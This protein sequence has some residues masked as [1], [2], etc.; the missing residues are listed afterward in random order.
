MLFGCSDDNTEIEINK[1]I[2]PVVADV[3]VVVSFAY[4]TGHPFRNRS[5]RI[6]RQKRVH[7]AAIQFH[8][9]KTKQ[10]PV[11]KFKQFFQVLG[12]TINAI[13]AC[14]G[15]LTVLLCYYCTFIA[16]FCKLLIYK[17]VCDRLLFFFLAR[18]CSSAVQKS[19]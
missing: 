17:R 6:S 4:S 14:K 9:S 10:K 13:I 19:D 8:L 12:Q 18:V 5:V 11:P 1:Q 2:E 7:E 15:I 3:Y 16:S